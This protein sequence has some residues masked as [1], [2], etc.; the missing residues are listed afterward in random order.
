[1]RIMVSKS[2]G[3]KEKSRLLMGGGGGALFSFCMSVV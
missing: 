1:M 2:E 3:R